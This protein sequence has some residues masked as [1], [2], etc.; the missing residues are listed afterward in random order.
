MPAI[1]S[2]KNLRVDPFR[3]GGRAY[4]HREHEMDVVQYQTI[5]PDF[6]GSIAVARC[7]EVAI[8]RVVGGIEENCL[9]AIAG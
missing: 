4:P 3:R 6:D 2:C 9:V 7:K 8:E 5:R 1:K